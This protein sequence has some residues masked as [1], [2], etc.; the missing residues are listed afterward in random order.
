METGRGMDEFRMVLE[1]IAAFALDGFEL[2]KTI[3]MTI[4]EGLVGERPQMLG[5]LEFRGIGGKNHRRKRAGKSTFG[6]VCQPARSTKRRMSVV[7]PA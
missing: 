3:K 1:P 2:V 7:S 4:D 6:L 5:R